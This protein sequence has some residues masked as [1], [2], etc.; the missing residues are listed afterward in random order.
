MRYYNIG[1]LS[2]IYIYWWLKILNKIQKI[3]NNKK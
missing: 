2:N 3:R 1:Y